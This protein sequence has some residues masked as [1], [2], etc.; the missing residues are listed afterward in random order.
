MDNHTEH[1]SPSLSDRV[2][3]GVEIERT[4]ANVRA[5]LSD[6]EATVQD[7]GWAL[8]GTSVKLNCVEDGEFTY[9]LGLHKRRLPDIIT[10]GLCGCSDEV[11]DTI[12]WRQLK[13][14][15][16][17]DGQ[18]TQVQG[19]PVRITTWPYTT[20]L[21]LLNEYYRHYSDSPSLLMVMPL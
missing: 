15:A 12:A 3:I 4:E 9:T 16:F 10:F 14:G 11:V 13:A 17:D 7:Q 19:T 21:R 5:V 18:I 6:L 20:H 2:A 1:D 8:V